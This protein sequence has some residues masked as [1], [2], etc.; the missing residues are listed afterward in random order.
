MSGSEREVKALKESFLKNKNLPSLASIDVHVLCGCVK[1]FLRSLR[2]PL[3]PMNLWATFSNASETAERDEDFRELYKA[4]NML[5][6]ANRDTLAYLI[7]HF[8]RIAECPEVKMPLSNF[9]K[10][11]GPTIVGYSCPDPEQNQMFAETNIQFVVMTVLLKIPT[12]YWNQFV[13]VEGLSSK[14][15]NSDENIDGYG[16]KFYLGK[17]LTA[18]NR[19]SKY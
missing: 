17:K 6:Q 1:D 9:A 16:S 8:Q 7:L 13:S 18:K 15:K 5:P 4:V 10:V 2:E 14:Q 12:D 19:F 3:I 11:F